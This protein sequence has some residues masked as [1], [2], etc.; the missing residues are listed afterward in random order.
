MEIVIKLLVCAAL[1]A[2]VSLSVSRLYNR[3]DLVRRRRSFK[4]MM[5]E[6]LR[7]F[8]EACYLYSSGEMDNKDV[9][10]KSLTSYISGIILLYFYDDVDKI[11]CNFQPILEDC[12]I[13]YMHVL[14]LEPDD[15]A[16]IV[17]NNL[18]FHRD[19][20]SSVLKKMEEEKRVKK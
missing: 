1:S 6:D 17:N 2:S 15:V 10:R 11:G 5:D 13:R 19:I 18:A 20:R 8:N 9:Y 14:D 12:A 16:R 4:K 3:L 7:D